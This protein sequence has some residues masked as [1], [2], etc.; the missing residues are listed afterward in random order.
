MSASPVLLLHGQPGSGADFAEVVDALP[1]GTRVLAPDRPGYGDNPLP[2]AGYEANARW[3]LAQLDAAGIERAVLVGHSWG[4]GVAVTAAALAPER[5]QGLVLLASV[6]PGC[7]ALSDRVLAGPVTGEVAAVV[8]WRLTPWLA[9]R[10]VRRRVQS[11]GRPLE[12][13]EDVYSQTWAEAGHAHGAVWRSFLT[14]QRELVAAEATLGA[15]LADVRAPTLVLGDPDDQVVPHAAA[16]ALHEGIAGSRL[17]AT[18]GSGH[19]VPR[20]APVEVARAVADVTAVAADSA[21]ADART[22]P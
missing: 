18:P 6:G 16:R 8:A 3:A 12:A 22:A 2:A 13:H 1:A 20:R 9:R 10:V 11:L 14:E 5:V 21:A 15:R 7:V 17:R 19:H 4:G